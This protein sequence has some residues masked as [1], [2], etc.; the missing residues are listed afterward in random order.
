MLRNVLC[1]FP[2]FDTW[3]CD[4][5]NYIWRHGNR[6][7]PTDAL[8][9]ARATEPVRRY[10][11]RQFGRLAGQEDVP[12]V[13]EKT[14]ANTL[15]V[16]FVSA[17]LPDAR[18]VHIVRDGRDAAVSAIKR[19]QASLEPVYLM[20]KARYVPLTD[21][22]YYA[23]RYAGVRLKRLIKREKKLSTWG[24]RF[25]ELD[26]IARSKPLPV[27]CALQWKACVTAATESLE[28]LPDEVATTVTYEE[29]VQDPARHTAGILRFLGVE[30]EPDR[31]D[32]A[33]AGVTNASVGRWQHELDREMRRNV[34]EAIG[35]TLTSLGY[36]VEGI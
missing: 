31:L 1:A 21:L 28:K 4:E 22:P 18:Y 25:E 32:E 2:E 17:V 15:R 9:P 26:E 36:E 33:V 10:I 16:E 11:R 12:H 5:I 8:P 3:D 35:P 7:Y 29:F 6:S 20:K 13:V 23:A 24:P 27:T 19:W 14:C 34:E 30:P